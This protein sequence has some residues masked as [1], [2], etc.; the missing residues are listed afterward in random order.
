MVELLSSVEAFHPPGAD[1]RNHTSQPNSNGQ[2]QTQNGEATCPVWRLVS[3]LCWDDV[4]LFDLMSAIC[5]R[6]VPSREK[7]EQSLRRQKSDI[8]LLSL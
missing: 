5:L 2:C 1:S 6:S 4:G 7:G 8:P 3:A